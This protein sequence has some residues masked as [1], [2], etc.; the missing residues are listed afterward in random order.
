MNLRSIDLNLLVVLDAL[1]AERSVRRAGE[2]IGLSQS[3]T[4]HALERLRK[5]LSDDLLVRAASGMEPTPRALALAAPLRVALQGIE[6]A[7]APHRFDPAEARDT[8]VLAVETYET[9]VLLPGLVD[10]MRREAPHATLTVRS[11]STEEILAGL[12]G[13]RVDVAIGVLKGLPDRFMTCGL[14]AD[15]HACAMRQDHPLAQAP[16]TLEQYLAAPHLRVSMT[17]DGANAVDAA[18]AARGLRRKVTMQLPHGLA[19]VVA[20]SRSDL[21]ASVTRGAAL[22][23]AAVAPLAV[24]DLPFDVPRTEFRLAW[25]RRFNDSPAHVWLRRRLVAIGAL[26]GG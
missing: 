6:T 1:L 12:D 17:G 25:N 26:A 10:E 13:G 4:S 24:L 8:F 2:R 14:L 7:L 23:F 15:G 16:L 19:A 20:L 11:G 18:L 22:G 5:L 3:A 21:V 9:I